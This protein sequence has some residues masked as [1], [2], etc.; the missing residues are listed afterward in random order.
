MSRGTHAT[1]FEVVFT[2]GPEDDPVSK[3]EL[4]C[5]VV[6]CGKIYIIVMHSNAQGQAAWNR[7]SCAAAQ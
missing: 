6:P 4:S 2:W 1:L 7:A 5:L 3:E